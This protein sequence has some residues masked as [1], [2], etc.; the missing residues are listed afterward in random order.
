MALI[1]FNLVFLSFADNVFNVSMLDALDNSEFNSFELLIPTTYPSVL[2]TAEPQ[3]FFS[4]GKTLIRLSLTDDTIP[5]KLE[6]PTPVLLVIVIT[7][8]LIDR[9]VL[10]PNLTCVP[11]FLSNFI[12]AIS[13]SVSIAT[14]PTHLYVL[15]NTSLTIIVSPIMNEFSK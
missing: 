15:F 6:S 12:T 11:Y 5:T 7:G 1:S 9:F 13:F 2:N 3:S 10:S 8:S 14:S 4:S